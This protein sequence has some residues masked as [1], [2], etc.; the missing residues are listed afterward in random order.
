MVSLSVLIA[1]RLLK[2]PRV[3]IN[4]LAKVD[5]G[6]SPYFPA[7]LSALKR[8]NSKIGGILRDCALKNGNKTLLHGLL[9]SGEVAIDSDLVDDIVVSSKYSLLSV[10]KD[11]GYDVASDLIQ[12]QAMNQ[13]RRI[14]LHSAIKSGMI[15]TT[16]LRLL[17]QTGTIAPRIVNN[18]TITLAERNGYDDEFLDLLETLADE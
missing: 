14:D 16:S 5:T 2:F 8:H 13:I 11:L 1:K 4:V 6:A 10:L 3:C 18:Q 9:R 17:A 15:D 7:L 12:L